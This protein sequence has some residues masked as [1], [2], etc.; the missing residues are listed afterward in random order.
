MAIQE[1]GYA[2]GSITSNACL[3]YYVYLSAGQTYQFKATATNGSKLDTAMQIYSQ[4]VNQLFY[5]NDSNG[6]SDSQITFNAATSGFYY[7]FVGAGS[8]GSTGSFRLSAAIDTAPVRTIEY[9]GDNKTVGSLAVNNHINSI[10]DFAGDH[11]WFKI[12]LL[13]GSQYKFNLS[14]SGTSALANASLVLRDQVGRAIALNDDISS[15]NLNSEFT[16]TATRSGDYFLDA[17]GFWRWTGSYTLSATELTRSTEITS[18]S[19]GN[20]IGKQNSTLNLGD[21]LYIDVNFSNSVIVTGSPTLGINIGDSIVLATYESGSGSGVLRFKYTIQAEQNDSN[22][23]SIADNAIALSQGKILDAQGNAVILAHSGEAD[24]LNY[25]VDTTAP[26]ASVSSLLHTDLEMTDTTVNWNSITADHTIGLSGTVEAGSAV[27]LYDGSTLLGSANTLGTTWSYKT[28][29]LA[30]GIHTLNIHAVDAAGNEST[31]AGGAITIN[32]Q[33]SSMSG[34]GA[35][36]V[37]SALNDVTGILHADTTTSTSSTWGI[38]QGNFDDAWHY[39]YTGNGVTIALIDTGIDFNN[40]D[41]T[42]KISRWSW[43]FVNNDNNPMDDNGHGTFVASEI[44]ALNN[45]VGLTGAA[46]DAELMVLKAMD[47]SGSGYSSTV[48]KAV[49]YAVDKGADIINMSLAGN[50]YSGYQAALQYAQEHDV[51]VVMAAGNNG[52]STPLAPANYAQLFS[53]CIAV[54]ATQFDI[55]GVQ[56]LAAFSNQAGSTSAY[57]YVD[58]S[59]VG[60]YGYG[61]HGDTYISEGTSMAAPY[62]ASEAA[63]LLSANAGLSATQIAQAITGT[64]HAIL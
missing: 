64:T 2:L 23:I 20:S 27:Y 44:A 3:G 51:L 19:L 31:I 48:C 14:G 6:S 7:I 29:Y 1:F 40:N 43:D 36:N 18:V 21:T 37:L 4:G 10:I 46:F 60:V 16:H 56:S 62:A 24:N 11:D 30:N 15:S 13:E 25:K 33:W 55:N 58:A 53:N 63:I 26:L 45:G 61:L 42:R 41:L 32:Q 47:A 12:T 54:G 38:N 57:N 5:N 8:T 52:N 59:G 39:G 28:P 34:W 35:L 49:R 22:G 9:S 50:D 17:S